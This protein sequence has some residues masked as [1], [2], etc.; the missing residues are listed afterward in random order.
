MYDPDNHPRIKKAF[1]SHVGA[2]KPTPPKPPSS[3]GTCDRA[4][5]TS[6]DWLCNPDPVAPYNRVDIKVASPATGLQLA[7]VQMSCAG[8]TIVGIVEFKGQKVGATAADPPHEVWSA[9][10]GTKC[11]GELVVRLEPFA[12]NT[13][14]AIIGQNFSNP[15]KPNVK[16]DCPFQPDRPFPAPGC[17]Q[18]ASTITMEVQLGT[19][20]P[21]TLTCSLAGETSIARGPVVGKQVQADGT[22][23]VSIDTRIFYG[24]LVGTC[25]PGSIPVTLHFKPSA[26]R[27]DVKYNPFTNIFGFPASS[28]FDVFFEVD[29]PIGTLH[30]SAS[31]PARVT[32]TIDR[33]PPKGS[34]YRET[35]SVLLYDSSGHVVGKLVQGSHTLSTPTP[36]RTPP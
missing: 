35:S 5:A 26:G 27:I 25:D 19:N 11:V 17:D 8:G 30:N 29:T 34:T 24:K 6:N 9:D 31:D 21:V 23:L 32:A 36:T 33:I 7:G 28:F 13:L 15:P 20:A 18:Q 4:S 12:A 10:F 2:A 14:P 3:N 1:F 22:V 16:P